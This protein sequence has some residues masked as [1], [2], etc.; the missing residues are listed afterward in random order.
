MDNV[1]NKFYERTFSPDIKIEKNVSL[2]TYYR[3]LH[4][5]ELNVKFYVSS[6]RMAAASISGPELSKNWIWFKNEHLDAIFPTF[7]WS[8][9]EKTRPGVDRVKP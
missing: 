7:K 2:G 5:R 6:L 1:F 3:D 8:A 4:S 9:E